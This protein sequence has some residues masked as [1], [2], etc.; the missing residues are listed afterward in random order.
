M[1]DRNLYAGVKAGF[2]R[3]T[4]G[5][6]ADV[7]TA[8]S[9]DSTYVDSSVSVG[10]ASTNVAMCDFIDSSGASDAAVTGETLWVHFEHYCD[11]NEGTAGNSVTIV[12]GSDQPWLSFRATGTS[13]QYGLYYNSGTGGSPTWTSLVTGLSGGSTRII[14]DI[15]VTL[16]SPHSYEIYVGSSLAGSGTFTAASFTSAD[17]LELRGSQTFTRTR[18][19]SQVMA[20]VG[21]C[22]VGGKVP[23]LKASGAGSNSGMTGA[24]TDVNEAIGS[25][26]SLVTSGTA[27][28]KTTFAMSD[29]P[30]LASGLVVTDLWHSFRAKNDGTNPTNLKSVK[31]VG[32]VDTSSSNVSGIGTG[33]GGFTV[34]YSG[35]SVSDINGMELG[36]ESA[37]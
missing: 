18:T 23:S 20:C 17:A 29:L 35:L 5:T 33:F 15:K 7:T 26:A 12:N 37:A 25:D 21:Y 32:G 14:V 16:G 10:V 4:A 1:A 6:I 22:T 27:A 34:R 2:L 9:F 11:G 30:S 36:W 19:Y 3:V 8:G 24:Y 28:Q 13:G 31:R